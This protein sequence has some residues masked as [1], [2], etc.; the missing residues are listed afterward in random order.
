MKE[1]ILQTASQMFLSQ[2]FKTTTMDDI[3]R[4]MGVSKKTLYK[5]FQNKEDLVKETTLYVFGYI[6]K[7]IDKIKQQNLNP[8][9]EFFQ[10]RKFIKESVKTTSFSPYA[11]LKKYYPDIAQMLLNLKKQYVMQSIEENLKRGIDEGIYKKNMDINFM[12]RWYFGNVYLLI[13]EENFPSDEFDRREI[14]N[15]FI[16]IFLQTITNKKGKVLLKKLKKTY[17]I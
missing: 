16:K 8:I 6:Y 2:G 5:F 13:S 17:G 9:E 12:K 4:E 1:R 3:A 10:I 7:N 11:Q 14:S 15:T